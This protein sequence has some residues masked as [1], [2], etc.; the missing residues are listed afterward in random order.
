MEAQYE[1]A[2][3][4]NNEFGLRLDQQQMYSETLRGALESA[5]A[6]AAKAQGELQMRERQHQ[7][8][9]D[10]IV[11]EAR[12][13]AS[14]L[15]RT[16]SDAT[17]QEVTVLK[18]QIDALQA[19]LVSRNQELEQ[20]LIADDQLRE[21]NSLAAAAV[22]ELDEQLIDERSERSRLQAL[23]QEANSRLKVHFVENQRQHN[24]YEREIQVKNEAAC[25]SFCSRGANILLRRS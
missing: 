3:S 23:L 5:K 19:K 21:Q 25:V 8:E 6:A 12:N 1:E 22:A 13:G 4:A 9:V 24:E 17:Q 11:Q 2:V 7:L 14:Q 16:L 18:M 15:Q 10:A 20:A